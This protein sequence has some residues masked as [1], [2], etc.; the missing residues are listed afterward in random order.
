MTRFVVI[1]SLRRGPLYPFEPLDADGQIAAFQRMEREA[2]WLD[3]RIVWRKD[4]RPERGLPR[5]KEDVSKVRR[6]MRLAERVA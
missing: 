1:A 2:E 4:A 5:S 6:M 3:C